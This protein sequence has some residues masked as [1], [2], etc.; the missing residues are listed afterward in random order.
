VHGLTFGFRG[1]WRNGVRYGESKL[2]LVKKKYAGVGT[3]SSLANRF[4]IA[5]RNEKHHR[6]VSE[7]A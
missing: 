5:E 7:N 2:L 6:S 3:C 1:G 4:S